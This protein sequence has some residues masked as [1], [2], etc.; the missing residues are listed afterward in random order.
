MRIIKKKLAVALMLVVSMSTVAQA[1]WYDDVMLRANE[2]GINGQITDSTMSNAEFVRLAVNIVEKKK[3]ISYMEYAR[4]N[5]YVLKEEM[6]DENAPVT[7]QSVAKVIS[8]MLQLANADAEHSFADW[9][10]TCP[11]CK[12]DIQK[13]YASGIMLGYE[14][15]TFRGRYYATRAEITATIIRAVDYAEGQGNE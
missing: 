8:R 3:D 10:I 15:G 5:G 4:K 6:T 13:C 14:D 1:Q 9:E 11:K 7:R 2:I 12:T